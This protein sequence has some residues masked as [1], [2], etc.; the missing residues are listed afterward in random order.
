M[1]IEMKRA[2]RDLACGLLRELPVL[3][4]LA[5]IAYYLR[6]IMIY[7]GAIWYLLHSTT[8]VVG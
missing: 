6:E 3:I 5:A 7:L 2:I 8:G 1:P 4:A